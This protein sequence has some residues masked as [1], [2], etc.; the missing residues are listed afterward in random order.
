MQLVKLSRL[1]ASE[2]TSFVELEVLQR[3]HSDDCDRDDCDNER[4][5]VDS[6][7]I[8]LGTTCSDDDM[9]PLTEEEHRAIAAAEPRAQGEVLETLINR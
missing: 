3:K 7:K 2:P 9:Q 5:H 6:K 4:E 8:V 1:E